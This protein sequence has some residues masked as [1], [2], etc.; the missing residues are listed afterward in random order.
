MLEFLHKKTQLNN[1]APGGASK[2]LRRIR[3]RIAM[4]AC[5]AVMTVLLTVVIV[6]GMTAAWYTNVVQSGGLIFQVET[7]GVNVDATVVDMTIIAQPGDEGA[8]NLTAVNNGAGMVDITV[9]INKTNMDPRMQQRLYFYVESQET[10]YGETA[11]RSYVTA[12]EGYT[13]QVF[14]G[15]RLSLTEQYHNAPALKWC[16]V[17][18][19]LGYYVLGRASNGTVAVEEY[20]QPI[21]YDYDSATFDA[22]GNLQ[23]VDGTTTAASFLTALSASDGYPGTIDT[24][25]K[26]GQYYQV[27]VDDNGYGVYAYLC[28]YEEVESNTDFDTELGK[29]ASAGNPA[30]YSALLTVNAQ[31]AIFDTITVGSSAALLSALESGEADSVVLS[32]D[33]TLDSGTTINIPAGTDLLLDLNGH[34]LTTNASD[35]AINMESNST[36]TVTDGTI[37]GNGTGSFTNLT[38]A[39]LTLNDVIVT[40]Y[41]RGV[42]V[43]DHSGTGLD[44]IVHITGSEINASEIAVTIYGNGSG[45]QQTSKLLIENSKLTGDLYAISGN[46]SIYGNGRWGTEIEIISSELYQNGSAGELGAAIYHPQPNSILNI[47]DSSLVGY[48]GMVIKGGTVTITESSVIGVGDNPKAATLTTSGYT[49][50]ADGIYVE[51]GYEYEI[52]LTLRDSS[53]LSYY[54]LGLRIFEENSKYVTYVQEGDNIF[55]N[56]TKTSG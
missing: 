38:G 43:A 2:E 19:V 30:T 53:C 22:N 24:T 32:T 13:Y 15:N 37:S 9:T 14:G 40:G 21:E 34:T 35:Y 45:S 29:A 54:N 11:Q 48:N 1:D 28:T 7:M 49:D 33:V 18:D 23:T 17:Y 41:N 31:A 55:L 42:N 51:T 12:S 50:T 39:D 47:Y 8:V 52:S 36:L 5:L 26:V 10:A 44:S 4:Q 25:Q 56:K 46:G 6:F 3:K 20:L 27:A 16:W